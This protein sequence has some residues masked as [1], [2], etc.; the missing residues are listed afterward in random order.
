MQIHTLIHTLLFADAAPEPEILA[1]AGGILIFIIIGFLLTV[2]GIIVT[3]ILVV[4]F[5]RNSKNPPTPPP[6][7]NMP[8]I[9]PTP[10][11]PPYDSK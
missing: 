10:Q 3:I 8:P 11:T 4:R 5:F 2:A 1:V 7:P 6:L 9:P